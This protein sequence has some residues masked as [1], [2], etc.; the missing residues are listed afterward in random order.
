VK[1]AA[2]VARLA[3]AAFTVGAVA[4]KKEAEPAQAASSES[5]GGGETS[6]AGAGTSAGS[7]DSVKRQGLPPMP[8]RLGDGS[9]A[10]SDERTDD[11]DRRRRSWGDGARPDRAEMRAKRD[12]RRAETLATYDADKNGE[13]DD[14]ER[15]LMHEGRVAD[16]VARR[17]TNADGK[18]TKDELDASASNRRRSPPDFESIDTNKDGFVTVEEM[19]AAR[20]P[21]QF[22]DRR[23]RDRGGRRGGR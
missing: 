3:L 13:L 9:L 5:G 7:A 2:L 23:D 21:R 19:A 4:C 22:R 15:Q 6:Q 12:E 14:E 10:G 17:D 11:G 16:M 18:L 8:R 20:P 1:A